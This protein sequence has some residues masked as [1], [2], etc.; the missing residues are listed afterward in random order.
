MPNWVTN[1][2][3]FP[4]S[5]ETKGE[6][7]A[8]VRSFLTEEDRLDFSLLI[9]QPPQLYTGGLNAENRADFPC[10][11]LD[12]NTENWGTKWNTDSSCFTINDE[13]GVIEIVFDTAW[14]IPY[15]VISAIN[16]R[17]QTSFTHKY[18]ED[19]G[20]FWGIETWGK[21]K[22]PFEDKTICRIEKRLSLDADYR[23]LCIELNGHDPLDLEED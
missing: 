8:K 9:P 7:L 15:P 16:N 1:K 5:P 3:V 10:N 4:F 23:D 14:S 11:W 13:E 20:G 12:W 21:K 18:L 6:L 17:L 19:M 22:A 2:L